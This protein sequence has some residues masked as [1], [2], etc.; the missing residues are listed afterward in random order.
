[1]NAPPDH[2]DPKAPLRT[3]TFD[4]GGMTCAACASRIETVVGR[5]PGVRSVSVNLPLER[6][7]IVMTA[8]V[9][10]Q[11]VTDV[12]DLAGY[13]ANPRRGTASERRL[14]EEERAA[15]RRAEDR[16]TLVLFVGSALLTLPLM[17]PMLLKPFGF[18]WHP[19]PWTEFALAAPVQF[20]AGWRFYRGA[21]K[22]IRTGGATM[23]VLVALGTSA[24]FFFSL[25]MILRHGD[26][27][28]GHLYF[29]GAAAVITLVLFG[30]VLE[31][32]ARRGTTEAVRALIALRPQ[33]ARLRRHGA[34]A[35]A[36]IEEVRS[37]DFVEIRP[38]ERFPV[39]G[40]IT[41]GETEADESLITGESVPVAKHVGDGVV[42]GALNGG[43]LVVI[44]ATAIGEDTTLARITRMVEAA[45]T[46]KAPVQRLVDRI[47]AV[48]VPVVIAI[49][50]VAF[51]GWL[52]AGHDVETALIAAVSVLVIA[53]P[54][55]L[56]LATPAALVAGTG[57]AARA[58][59]LVKDIEALERV[60]QVDVV[61]LD[62]TGTLTLGKPVVAEVVPAEGFT[63]ATLLA[64][65]GTVQGPSEHPLGK[66]IR[67][68]AVTD[69]AV[70][71][72]VEGFRA[73]VGEG[74]QGKVDGRSVIAGKPA[75]LTSRGVDFGP[76]GRTAADLGL[77]G[78]TV[79]AVATDGKLA[80]LIALADAVHPQAKAAIDALRARSIR[81]MMVTGDA[82]GPAQRVAAELG[83]GAGEVCFGVRPEGK[84]QVVRELVTSGARAAMVGDGINDA[85]ALAAAHVGIAMGGGTDA[86][87]ETASVALMRSNPIL[88]PGAID[89]ARRTVAKIRQN[90]F[91][92]FVYNVVG[93]PLAAFGLLSPAI[94]GA[95][96]AM[97]S[98][99]VV[100]NS[101]TLRNWKP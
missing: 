96:M 40:T 87:I 75:Y 74:V 71:G 14:A 70:L 99:S 43:G 24:A 60:A 17:L 3:V 94:A 98:V 53:C 41:E 93:V 56:G 52:I 72:D 69:G 78:A 79:T 27:A 20:I 22:A 101:L 92:A 31:T 100:V 68:A 34:V 5:L 16:Q 29:E 32:R 11:T 55:A 86:A 15:E 65:A 47:S 38:G 42:T 9:A 50:G 88:V 45:Q 57:A 90:L 12:V 73:V 36:P 21:W 66:A 2:A 8:D 1:M 89:I 97:S 23:D 76:L 28:H 49:A 58:G 91:W 13:S 25:Y 39:D 80:G 51:A 19:A 10:D 33:T 54:C 67:A 63:R 85:P 59:I 62:K 35:D 82:E 26:H 30:K 95:A 64:L 61:V 4:V 7:D 18:P 77:G 6:A 81:V 48:F 83:L 46:G 84:V 44:A 37:G